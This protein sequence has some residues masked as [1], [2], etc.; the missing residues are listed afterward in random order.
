[1]IGLKDRMD[2]YTPDSSGNFTVLTTP[3]TQIACRVVD[4]R[5][6]R[7]NQF[8]QEPANEWYLWV[9]PLFSF[10]TECQVVIRGKKYNP[11]PTSE[12]DYDGPSASFGGGLKVLVIT[13][14]T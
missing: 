7:S 4:P 2:V 11:N 8:R 12:T 1:M 13:E 9:D 6:I 3:N 14:T 5:K 10:P